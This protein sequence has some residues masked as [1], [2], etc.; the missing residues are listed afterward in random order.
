MTYRHAKWPIPPVK[1]E[2]FTQGPGGQDVDIDGLL[3]ILQELADRLNEL[4]EALP[5]DKG[6]EV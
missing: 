6:L 5:S 4:H 2:Q 1:L 3:R